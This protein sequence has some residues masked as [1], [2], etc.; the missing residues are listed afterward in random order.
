MLLFPLIW[1]FACILFLCA[2][3]TFLFYG[4]PVEGTILEEKNV[5]LE[6]MWNYTFTGKKCL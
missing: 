5:L 4:C 6:L 2:S 1:L 3:I